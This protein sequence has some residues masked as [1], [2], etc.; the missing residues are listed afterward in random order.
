M[1]RTPPQITKEKV[2]HRQSIILHP[3][4]SKMPSST[5]SSSQL[6]PK[7]RE[8]VILNHLPRINSA[9]R[10]HRSNMFSR[11]FRLLGLSSQKMRLASLRTKSKKLSSKTLM[12]LT[13]SS[14]K[15]TSQGRIT[16]QQKVTLTLEDQNSEVH[17][18]IGKSGKWWKWSRNKPLELELSRPSLKQQE[19]MTF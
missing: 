9:K 19:S 7:K 1:I 15:P 18:K 6:I 5:S 10:R 11:L 12:I 8:I 3:W 16:T 13:K 14:S 17:L 2:S 4:T